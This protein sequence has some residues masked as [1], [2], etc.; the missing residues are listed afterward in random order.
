MVK[1]VSPSQT[2]KKISLKSSVEWSTTLLAIDVKMK[3]ATTGK[4]AEGMP[5]TNPK[6][7]LGN[8]GMDH[9]TWTYINKDVTIPTKAAAAITVNI[10]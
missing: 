3:P 10:Y 7:F 6:K 2:S 8:L 9:I 4:H 1:K 5:T